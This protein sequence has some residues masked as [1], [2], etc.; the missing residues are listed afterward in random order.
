LNG[1]DPL[2]AFGLCFV[3]NTGVVLALRALPPRP[4][5]TEHDRSEAALGREYPLLLDATR[6]LLPLSYV[7]SSTLAPVLPYRLSVL[8][9]GE[10]P[11]SMVAATWMLARFATLGLMT[12]VHVWHGRWA[13]LALGGTALGCGV[14]LTLLAPS[15]PL[16]ILGLFLFGVGM[17]VTYF[18]SIYYSLA[19]GHGAVG[20]GGGFEALIGLGYVVGPLVGI[21]ARALPFG[22]NQALTTAGLASAV[23]LAGGAFS[24][25]PYFAARRGRRAPGA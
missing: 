9:A 17:G 5:A 11:E 2:A 10:V 7:L 19:V 3:A 23:A 15:L 20:A 21:A 12:R 25:K 14:A 6:W 4:G 16:A 1:L 24:L 8:G 18:A 13:A 22:T